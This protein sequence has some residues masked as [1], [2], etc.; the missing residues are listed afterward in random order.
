[1]KC[2]LEAEAAK[3]VEAKTSRQIGEFLYLSRSTNR[4]ERP[5]NE[6]ETT[7]K[8]QGQLRE[9]IGREQTTTSRRHRVLQGHQG[10][11]RENEADDR[12]QEFL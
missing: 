5:K 12:R 9:K 6:A 7:G 10:R 4:A 3:K 8:G 1:M 11:G 2:F